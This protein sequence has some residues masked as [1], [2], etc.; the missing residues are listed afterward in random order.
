MKVIGAIR[1]T[2]EKMQECYEAQQKLLSQIAH[3]F[4]PEPTMEVPNEEGD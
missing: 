2:K 1:L 4:S 3:G